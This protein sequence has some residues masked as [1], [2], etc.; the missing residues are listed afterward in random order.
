MLPD[1]L[2]V[3]Y[4]WLNRDVFLTLKSLGNFYY[5]CV[6]ITADCFYTNLNVD[7]E[8]E[9]T[10]PQ[11]FS[12]DIAFHNYYATM[13]IEPM[14]SS[15][16][17]NRWNWYFANFTD[18]VLILSPQALY[19]NG[20]L[21]HFVIFTWKHLCQ[22]FFLCCSSIRKEALAQG[23]ACEFCNIFKNAFFYRTPLDDCCYFTTVYTLQLY[24][25]GNFQVV[26]S[27]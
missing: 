4:D 19:K 25:A 15:V 11:N 17:K 21:K 22:N 3:S 10:P 6:H 18:L 5:G 2:S 14:I 20:F 1:Y 9:W 8:Y 7:L 27:P 12:V 24:I 16:V 23:F 26:R 13:Q